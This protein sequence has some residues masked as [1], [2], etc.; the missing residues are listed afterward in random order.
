MIRT[1]LFY[2]NA[3]WTS[4]CTW[5]RKFS[6][7]I[8]VL[9]LTEH[10]CYIFRSWGHRACSNNVPFC[11]LYKTN[12]TRSCWGVSEQFQ[13]CA[14]PMTKLLCVRC[15]NKKRCMTAVSTKLWKHIFWLADL[16]SAKKAVSVWCVTN[17]NSQKNQEVPILIRKNIP[18]DN[19]HR[20]KL[21]TT[22]IHGFCAK[23]I[24]GNP[25]ISN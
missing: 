15:Y 21:W 10:Y 22:T 11:N 3:E 8:Y 25:K 19:D 14:V 17:I 6:V 4:S 5:N 20:W 24:T 18:P 1:S 9:P 2:N 16:P 7:L 23:K 13:Y 12:I